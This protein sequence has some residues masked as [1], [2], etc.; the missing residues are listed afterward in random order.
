M[1]SARTGSVTIICYKGMNANHEANHCEANHH[2]DK[3][4]DHDG[5]AKKHDPY[6]RWVMGNSMYIDGVPSF[7]REITVLLLM[8]VALAPGFIE[9]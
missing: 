2:E 7:V 5:E 6:S 1:S 3:A 9:S 8:G 4:N